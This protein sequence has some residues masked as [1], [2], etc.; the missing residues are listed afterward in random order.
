MSVERLVISLIC[1]VN[2]SALLCGV[3]CP[4]SPTNRKYTHLITYILLIELLT[5]L[6][7]IHILLRVIFSSTC[8]HN[9]I[10]N[11]IYKV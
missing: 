2:E 11:S 5:F 8:H 4:R 7:F 6:N 3:L 10:N 1:P 9:S